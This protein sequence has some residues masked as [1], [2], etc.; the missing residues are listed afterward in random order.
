[1]PN[2]TPSKAR[3]LHELQRQSP[4][5]QAQLKRAIADHELKRALTHEAKGELLKAEIHFQRAAHWEAKVAQ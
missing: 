1:M 2:T 4:E 3:L 5:Q